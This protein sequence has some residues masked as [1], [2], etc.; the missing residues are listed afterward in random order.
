M[1]PMSYNKV[2][3]SFKFEMVFKSVYDWNLA[4]NWVLLSDFSILAILF[5]SHVFWLADSFATKKSEEMFKTYVS[6]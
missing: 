6:F 4:M 2:S 5:L 3:L 1:Y